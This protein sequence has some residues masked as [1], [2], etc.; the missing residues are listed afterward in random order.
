MPP[1]RRCSTARSTGCRSTST[2]CLHAVSGRTGSACR[3]VIQGGSAP[4]DPRPAGQPG[5]RERR[6]RQLDAAVAAFHRKPLEDQDRVLVLDIVVPKRTTGA[7]ALARPVLVALGLRPDGRKEVIDFRLAT[8]GSAARWERFLG[9]L[10]RRGLTGERLEM[11]C[12][13]GGS[14]PARRPVRRRSPACAPTS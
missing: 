13:D 5:D 14:R 2:R 6:G 1:R 7:G 4:A 8:A 10:I 3:V 9:D 11:L 12:V